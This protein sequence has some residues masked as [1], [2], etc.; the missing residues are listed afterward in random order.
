MNSYLK[1]I[2]DYINSDNVIDN[3]KN[4]ITDS[5]IIDTVLQSQDMDSDGDGSNDAEASDKI[6][7]DGLTKKYQVFRAA[8]CISDQQIMSVMPPP[9]PPKKVYI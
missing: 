5:E 6:L 9:L 8:N 2:P 1:K 3:D 7:F 4:Q